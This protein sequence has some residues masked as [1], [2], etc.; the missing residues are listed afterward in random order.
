MHCPLYDDIS[1]Q[2]TLT[3]NNINLTFQDFLVQDQFIQ[4]V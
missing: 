1:N 4:L 3:T 2:L